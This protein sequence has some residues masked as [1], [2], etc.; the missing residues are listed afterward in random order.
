VGFDRNY[1]FAGELSNRFFLNKPA[2]C[3]VDQLEKPENHAYPK[4]M[5]FSINNVKYTKKL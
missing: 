5:F 1:S 3:I 4:N 2:K